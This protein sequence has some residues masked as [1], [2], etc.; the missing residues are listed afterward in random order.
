[1]FVTAFFVKSRNKR[2]FISRLNGKT[3]D[4][5]SMQSNNMA[6]RATIININNDMSKSPSNNAEF[7]RQ[8]ECFDTKT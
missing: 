8:G 4:T 7:K 5:I 6:V 2:Q 3:N 1:M